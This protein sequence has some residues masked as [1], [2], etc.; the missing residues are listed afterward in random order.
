MLLREDETEEGV[1]EEGKRKP[2][3][4][5][6]GATG[7]SV[8][9]TGEIGERG[10]ALTTGMLVTI[11]DM[12]GVATSGGEEGGDGRSRIEGLTID[13]SGTSSTMGAAMID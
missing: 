7:R 6:E 2:R 3:P 11:G 1:R 12:T 9:D 5:Y 10:P 8:G 4:K 13:D